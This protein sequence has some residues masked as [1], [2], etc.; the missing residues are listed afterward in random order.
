[1]AYD[2]C[3]TFPCNST[4]GNATVPLAVLM[5]MSWAESLGVRAAM[6]MALVE[7]SANNALLPNHDLVFHYADTTGT[8]TGAI[9]A[10]LDTLLDSLLDASHQTVRMPMML[11]PLFSDGAR[12]ASLITAE[13]NVPV[14]SGSA[15]VGVLSNKNIFH[16]LQLY[17]DGFQK[18][19]KIPN[20]MVVALDEPT[21]EWCKARDVAH[22]TKV[23]TSRT[24]STDNH[25]TSGLKFKVLVDF[26]T[27]GQYLQPTRKHAEVVRYVEPAEFDNYAAQARERGFALVAASPLTRSSYHAEQDFQR[28][29]RARAL[30]QASP[31]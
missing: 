4:L 30:Q 20:S 5:P 25:A 26:L 23:L 24:G 16:L 11:G 29:Q 7:I 12:G 27:I 31:A 17:V 19:A 6:E 21:A 1:M 15:T 8:E 13:L 3:A 22:Y 14:L 18:G 9:F 10:S 2:C 28:L